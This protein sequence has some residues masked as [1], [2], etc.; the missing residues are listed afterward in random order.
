MWGYRARLEKDLAR[1]RTEGWLTADGEANI[2]SEL[3][4][5]QRGVGLAP[6]LS[7]LASVLLGFG[8]MSFVAA[9]WQE[10]P[11]GLR[12][13]MLFSLL[14]GGYAVADIFERR[15]APLIA[16]AAI[17]FSSALFGACIMLIS[18]MFHIEGD[19]SEA[20]LVWCGAALLGGTALRSNP[21]LAL[22]M[23]LAVVWWGM[24]EF[25]R[26]GIEWIFLPA[27][28]AISAAFAW[29]RWRPGLHL[30]ALALSAFVIFLGFEWQREDGH[31][32]VLSIGLAI[33]ALALFA[34][35]IQSLQ[36][37]SEPL[38]GYGIAMTLISSWALQFFRSPNLIVLGLLALLTIAGM[39][40]LIAHGIQRG[41]KGW[42]WLGY[43]GFSIEILLLYINTLGSMFSTSLFFL[44]AGLLVA[45][46]AYLATRLAK[47]QTADGV[48]T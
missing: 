46:L 41:H 42:M 47:R 32:L 4:R 36:S 45:A 35:R 1:W 15:G 40:A 28:A 12:L 33:V 43:A 21:S 3:A 22:A 20:V 17:L 14:A 7:V 9:H 44:V 29:Q 18:Q 23:I 31:V 25:D 34:E 16:D 6:V 48:T 8:A 37:F 27:W 38:L 39:L 19:A 26:P 24:R 10:M 30:S 2:L 5:R 13:G 11:R